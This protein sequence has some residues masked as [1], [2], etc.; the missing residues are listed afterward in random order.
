MFGWRSPQKLLFKEIAYLCGDA[1]A[2]TNNTHNHC[3][4]IFFSYTFKVKPGN[5]DIFVIMI[6]MTIS[7]PKKLVEHAPI[8][9]P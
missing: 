2:Y 4:N 3:C 1:C 8:S 9:A 5:F 6:R 7:P